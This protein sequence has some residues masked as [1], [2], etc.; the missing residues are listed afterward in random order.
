MRDG[1]SRSA[2]FSQLC[3]IRPADSSAVVVV[4]RARKA[5]LRSSG[6]RVE[7]IEFEKQVRVARRPFGEGQLVVVGI[8]AA[9]NRQ[10]RCE[11]V[12]SRRLRE[13]TTGR[14]SRNSG[15]KR[16][17]S[18][19]AGISALGRRPSAC[20]FW[21]RRGS[22]TIARWKRFTPWSMRP[23]PTAIRVNRRPRPARP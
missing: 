7:Q 5:I 3:A 16:R 2:L 13:M 8:K 20:R 11:I 6:D 10:G 21:R 1:P 17:F 4:S 23:E 9:R 22:S 15:K 19:P 12:S 18:L 14:P